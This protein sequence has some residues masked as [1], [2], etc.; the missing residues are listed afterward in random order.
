MIFS[1]EKLKL[2]E[3]QNLQRSEKQQCALHNFKYGMAPELLADSVRHVP[4]L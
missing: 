2:E 4:E 3:D 1:D